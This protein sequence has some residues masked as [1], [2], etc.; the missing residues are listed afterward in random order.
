MFTIERIFVEKKIYRKIENQ[1]SWEKV[2]NVID[3]SLLPYAQKLKKPITREDIIRL[4]EIK[5]KRISKYDINNNIQAVSKIESALDNVH[6]NLNHLNDYTIS[7]YQ[8]LLDK[9]GIDK[10]RKTKIETFDTI[11][12]KQAAIIS[13]KLFIDKKEGFIGFSLKEGELLSECTEFDDILIFREDGKYL[14]TKV[15]DKKFVGKNV[16]YGGIWKKNDKHMIYNLIYLNKINHNSYVKRFSIMSLNRDREYQINKN[17]E[18]VKILYITGNPNSESEVVE[19]KIHFR[20]KARKKEFMYDFG[21]IG[22]KGRFSKGN[23]LTKYPVTKIVRKELGQST[24][25][26]KD[27]WYE[28]SV[29]KLNYDKRGEPLGKFDTDDRILV[30]YTSGNY[31]V[32]HIDLS[33]RFNDNDILKLIKFDQK[34]IISCLHYIGTKRSYFLKRFYI[35]TTLSNRIFSFIDDSRGS[36][37]ICLSI[38]EDPVLTFNYRTSKGDKKDKEIKVNEF[39]PIK[40]WKAI[41][42]KLSGFLRISNCNIN[43]EESNIDSQETST[44]KSLTLF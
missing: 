40:K 20:S 17:I 39:V 3:N 14:V 6:D 22:I 16:K 43:K 12:V 7:Y 4:T 25:G 31:E 26:G 44:D 35:E 8:D 23:I 34:N 41:G 37:L 32:S 13:K 19:I 11:K 30:I 10:D 2:I 5:I 36:K 15:G 29:G 21:D 28:T 38:S 24:F 42:N 33:R 18:N 1:D 9:H 27:I